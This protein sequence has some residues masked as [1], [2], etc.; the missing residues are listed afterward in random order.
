VNAA[1]ASVIVPLATGVTLLAVE[2][3]KGGAGSGAAIANPC[4]PR[5]PF[6]GSAW[7]AKNG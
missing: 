7:G 1:V 3:A 4:R 2:L 5:P 6:A